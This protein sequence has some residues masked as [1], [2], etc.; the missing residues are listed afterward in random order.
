ML[1]REGESIAS[2]QGSVTMR[3]LGLDDFIATEEDEFVQKAL[4]WRQS[5]EKLSDVRAGI[6]GRIA[7]RMNSVLSP[8]IYFERAIRNAWQ[9][10][11]EGKEPRTFSIDWENES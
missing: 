10:Y 1:T 9:I 8:S 11:C 4:Y 6:R 3:I 2:R 5:L 7:A